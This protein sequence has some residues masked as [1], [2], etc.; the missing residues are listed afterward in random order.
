MVEVVLPVDVN[1]FS[2]VTS[3]AILISIQDILIKDIVLLSEYVKMNQ[4]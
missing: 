4:I 2:A 3:Y 1:Y